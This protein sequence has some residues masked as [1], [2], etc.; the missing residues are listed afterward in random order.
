M[1][2]NGIDGMTV[3]ELGTELHRGGKFIV[4]QYCISIVI[5]TYKIPSNIYFIK[6]G[7][8]VVSKSL[9]FSLISLLLGWWGLPWGPIYTIGALFTNLQ[10]GKDV[11]AQVVAALGSRKA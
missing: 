5:L 1:K 6:A 9:G 11:T 10:G 2:I 4:F 3:G 7:E 8:S